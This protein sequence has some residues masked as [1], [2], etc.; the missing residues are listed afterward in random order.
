MN[1]NVHSSTQDFFPV[2][3]NNQKLEKA[4]VS[5]SRRMDKQTV[6]GLYNGILFNNKENRSAYTS[7]KIDEFQ[8]HYVDENLVEEGNNMNT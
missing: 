3:I 6:N 1:K 2:F 4:W 8:K 5:I 7:N